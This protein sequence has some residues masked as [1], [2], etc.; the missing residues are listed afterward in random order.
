MGMAPAE[1]IAA[2]SLVGP[3]QVA[4]RLI[5]FSFLRRVSPTISARIA[6]AFHP[7]GA[8]LPALFG[9]VAAIRFVLL[10]GRAMV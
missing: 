10:H 2:A 8:A 3:A 6:A 1:A 5:E 4:A 9:P 7:F